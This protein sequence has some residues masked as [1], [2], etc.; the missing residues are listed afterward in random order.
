[1][2]NPIPIYIERH[3]PESGKQRVA[4]YCRVSSSSDEQMH[5]YLVQVNNYKKQ[6][7]E[8][9]SFIFVGVY[10]D[11]GISGSIAD[12]VPQIGGKREGMTDTMSCQPLLLNTKKSLY[13][14]ILAQKFG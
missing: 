7:S 11:A 3:E 12:V 13:Y 2:S 8:D 9:D 6:F 10:G 4:A 14:Q 5:S 1:M